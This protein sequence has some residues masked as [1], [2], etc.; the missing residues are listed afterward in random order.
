MSQE[1]VREIVSYDPVTGEFR[2]LRKSGPAVPGN[3]AGGLD[4]NGYWTLGFGGRK[5]YGHR[6]AWF[7]VHGK[8]PKHGIDHINGVRSDNRL[9]NLREATQAENVLNRPRQRNNLIGLK[10]VSRNSNRRE[11]FWQARFKKVWLGNF[12]TPEEAHEAYRKAAAKHGGG[13]ARLE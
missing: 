2:W 12:D 6:L 5:W 8:W 10:G 3:K 13:F 7:Y 11:R 1:R 9:C 4:T